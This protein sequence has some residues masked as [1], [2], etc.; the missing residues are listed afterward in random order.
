MEMY[1]TILE[2]IGK[3]P[4]V[5]LNHFTNKEDAEIYIK[6]EFMNPSGSIKDRM[7][8]HIINCAE[9]KGLLKP[10]GTIVE[11]TSGNT[12]TALAMIAAVKGYKCIFTMPDKMSKEKINAMRAFG[13]IVKITPTDVPGDSP[14]HYVNLAKKIAKETPGAFYV[15][16]YHNQSNIEAYKLT[17][18]PELWAQTLGKFDCF[19]AGTGTG[20][21][22]SGVG[23]FIKE[24]T[25]HIQ[26]VGVDPIGSVHYDLFYNKKLIEPD[27][28]KVEGI[29]EDIPCD[30]LDFSVIDRM[31]QT[32]DAQAF[33]T[34]RKLVKKEG[35]FCG[36]SSGS[37]IY[38]AQKMAKELGRGKKIIAVLTDSG[39]RY[40]SKHLD[41]VWMQQQGFMTEE[42]L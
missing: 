21:T 41:N 38:A 7:A 20:G 13:A 8:H 26:I 29:G 35:L 32:N 4:L 37:V 12:G 11:N 39:S 18:G 16:Q 19:I 24:K 5:K 17:L 1:N 34:A 31:I 30:A 40:L 25:N 6:C 22:V 15:N 14:E 33:A 28:Y 27:L 10:G 42:V 2:A 36:G 3:T 23:A 9:K